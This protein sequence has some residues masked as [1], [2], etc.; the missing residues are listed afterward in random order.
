MT[1]KEK[2]SYMNR[3]DGI[4]EI[5]NSLK[6]YWGL[7][8]GLLALMESSYITTE[9]IDSIESLLREAIKSMKDGVEKEKIQSWLEHIEEMKQKEVKEKKE[10]SHHAEDHLL[11]NFIL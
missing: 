9:L 5:L 11:E 8:D 4:I 1:E 3:R 6:G 2:A 7:A 10:E